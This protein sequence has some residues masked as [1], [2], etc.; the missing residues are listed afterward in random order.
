MAVSLA[1][2]RAMIRVTWVQGQCQ[3]AHA[4]PLPIHIVCTSCVPD[5]LTICVVTLYVDILSLP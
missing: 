1:G 4:C 5:H 3:K 2:S